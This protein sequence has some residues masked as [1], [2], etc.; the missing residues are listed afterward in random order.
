M[1]TFTETSTTQAAVVD[2]LSQPDVGWELVE[3]DKLERNYTDVLL[4]GDVVEA[5]Q[6]L[7]PILAERAGAHR[8]GDAEAARRAA[9]G[10]RRRPHRRQ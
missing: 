7:N 10:A 3:G 2:R 9:V 6:R 8:G 4:E 1:A 5:L